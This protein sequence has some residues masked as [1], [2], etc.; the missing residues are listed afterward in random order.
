MD[1]LSLRASTRRCVRCD[2]GSDYMQMGWFSGYS[3]FIKRSSVGR[4]AGY[5]WRDNYLNVKLNPGDCS[6]IWREIDW[7]TVESEVKTEAKSFPVYAVAKLRFRLRHATLSGWRAAPGKLPLAPVHFAIRELRFD[8][9]YIKLL[10]FASLCLF[11]ILDI[12]FI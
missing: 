5:K 6:L 9:K 11:K 10:L 4:P 3:V 1:R 12:A 2:P 8:L 7:T